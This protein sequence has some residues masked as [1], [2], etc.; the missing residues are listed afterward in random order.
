MDGEIEKLYR[1]NFITKFSDKVPLK[2]YK[3]ITA[4]GKH[5]E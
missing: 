5:N 4:K 1:S 2:R 3:Q